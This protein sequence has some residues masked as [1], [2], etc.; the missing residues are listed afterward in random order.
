M[1]ILCLTDFPVPDGDRWLWN[2]VPDNHDEVTFLYVRVRDQFPGWGK[3]FGYYPNLIRLGITAIQKVKRE[4]YDL[5]VAWEGKNGFPLAL[6]RWL[7]QQTM[8][9]LVILAFSI[10]GPLK[11]FP[12]LQKFGIRGADYLSV[13]T[14]A[15]QEFY[16]RQLGLPVECIRHIPL[17]THD[18]FGGAFGSEPGDFIFSGGRSGRD[19]ATLF[20]A[21]EGTGLPVV[22]NAR[23]FNLRGLR[24]PANVRVNDLQRP[25]IYRD[26]H[27]AARFAVVPLKRVDEAVGLTAILTA[28]A[29]GRAVICTSLAGT[30]EY[31]LDGKTGFLVPANDPKALR[32]ALIA[33]W[34]DPDLC[35]RMG[36]K[37]REVYT[38]LYTFTKFAQRVDQFLHDILQS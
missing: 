6:M 31:V 3:L 34:D 32:E 5:I 28:M 36:R 30:A 35:L 9:P 37:A 21:V 14:R 10:R 29:S 16:A 12:R 24:I 19:Y 25:D 11:A 15:E 27:W 1:R 26:Q 7:R 2:Y 20:Q 33:L 23:P 8:P 17:G 13:P 22:V 18:V 38:E 4:P